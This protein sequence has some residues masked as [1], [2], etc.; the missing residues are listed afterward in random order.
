MSFTPHRSTTIAFVATLTQPD[1]VV[2]ELT[3]SVHPA[4]SYL[5]GGAFE[6]ELPVASFAAG[7]YRLRLD[8]SMGSDTAHRETTFRVLPTE[9]SRGHR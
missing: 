7:E 1:G 8:L 4:S 3:R 2:R 9:S 5:E 6:L